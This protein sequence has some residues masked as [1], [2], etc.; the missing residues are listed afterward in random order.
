MLH[1]DTLNPPSG[2][3]IHVSNRLAL[4]KLQL[5]KREVGVDLGATGGRSKSSRVTEMVAN[6]EV[7]GGRSKL[8]IRGG[9][10]EVGKIVNGIIDR[11]VYI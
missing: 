7:I 2:M 3:F 5:I 8:K 1:S 6:L 9:V 4:K 11:V 10:A